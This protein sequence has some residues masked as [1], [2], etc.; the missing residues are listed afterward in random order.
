MKQNNDMIE[1]ELN[2]TLHF[3]SGQEIAEMISIS[4]NPDIAIQ[5][6]D[7]YI[8]IRGLIILQGEYNKASDSTNNNVESSYDG[9]T[10]AF[11]E[12]V[13]ETNDHKAQFSH[14]FPVE[15]S[16]PLYRVENLNDITVSV[17]SFDYELPDLNQLN[18]TALIHIHG[19]K[20]DTDVG[21]STQ[22]TETSQSE[23]E[24]QMAEAEKSSVEGESKE[25][26]NNKPEEHEQ[27]KSVDISEVTSKE[28][29]EEPV[30]K[31][32]ETTNTESE[33]VMEEP[34]KIEEEAEISETIDEADI[35]E[36]NSTEIE[37]SDEN[38]IDIQLSKNKEEDNEEDVKDVRFLTDL[39]GGEE[40]EEY[41]KM[42]IYIA[43]EDDTIESIAKR[44]E[45]STLQ[46]IK[47]NNLTEEGLE[48]G[49]LLYIP[50]KVRQ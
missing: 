5:K 26:V 38:E 46:L 29:E 2:E 40:E 35:I 27:E 4:L 41:S 44:Y 6:F 45:M 16:V 1:F 11:I 18:L 50:V 23:G 36:V 12:K 7:S 15:I 17:D 21:Q 9:K 19:I 31:M 42:K 43:Q 37:S 30:S 24:E 28:T 34:D 39:F 47:D 14:R 22:Q 13:M 3:E 25:S 49:Q 48:E 8:Q 33:E 20:G 32:E 10:K